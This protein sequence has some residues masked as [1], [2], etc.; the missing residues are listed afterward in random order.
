MSWRKFQTEWRRRQSQTQYSPSAAVAVIVIDSGF[1]RDSLIAARNLLGYWDLNNG[2]KVVAA[3]LQSQQGRGAELAEIIAAA[4]SEGGDPLNHGSIVLDRL[5]AAEPDLPVVLV[6]AFDADG[7]SIK[8]TFADGLVSRPGWTEGY[9]WAQALCREQGYLSVA[10]C[11]FGGFHHAMDGSGWESFQLGRV[12]GAG[13]PGHLIVAASGPGDGRAAHASLVMSE[14]EGDAEGWRDERLQ[15]VQ[16]GRTTYNLWVDRRASSDIGRRRD[17]ELVAWLDGRPVCHCRGIDLPPNIWNGKQQLTF[18]VD[19]RGTLTFVLRAPAGLCFDIFISESDESAGGA[20]FCDHIDGELVS[21]P[22]IF[23]H[24]IAVGLS[25]GQYGQ[26]P[27][28]GL[29]KPDILVPGAGPVSFRVP[30]VSLILA[31]YL[32]C[33]PGLD[34]VDARRLLQEAN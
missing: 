22:A 3:H 21:E 13:K 16:S 28:D 33:H 24:V 26:C 10:N 2:Y 32:A 31:H 29:S 7:S 18:S 25:E 12:V 20:H 6:R 27:I 11:S 9:L 15:A 30:E 5:L 4:E 17:F 19:G 34:A 14:G 1:S 8:T 23:A